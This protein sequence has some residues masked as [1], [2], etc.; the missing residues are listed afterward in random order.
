MEL[1]KINTIFTGIIA[2]STSLG[3]L[4]A[5]VYYFY[6][7]KNISFLQAFVIS[8]IYILINL[9]FLYMLKRQIL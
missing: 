4:F 3:V 8:E 7:V 6:Q 5:L 2:F 1:Q 9:S